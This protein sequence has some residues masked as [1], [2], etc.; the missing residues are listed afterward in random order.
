VIPG[1]GKEP[2]TGPTT[3]PSAVPK[4]GQSGADFAWSRLWVRGTDQARE[5]FLYIINGWREAEKQETERLQATDLQL[6]QPEEASLS[7]LP[8]LHLKLTRTE[9]NHGRL[10]VEEVIA[11]NPNKD[12]FYVVGMI[13]SADQYDKNQNL[14]NRVVEGFSYVPSAA[15]H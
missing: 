12:I 11:N 7:S 4:T 2:T 8:A 6:E 14:F 9:I 1:V 5:T 10:I 13:S 3:R 15:S